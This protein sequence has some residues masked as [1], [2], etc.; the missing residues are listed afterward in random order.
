MKIAAL[1]AVAGAASFA[2]AQ[3]AT[4]GVDAQAT[5]N[6]GEVIAVTISLDGT[7][8]DLGFAGWNI[9]VDVAGGT[10]LSAS[11]DTATA[12]LIDQNAPFGGDPT[13]EVS[14][15]TVNLSEG[16]NAFSPVTAF[17]TG[18]A[19]AT[20]MIDTAG[21]EPSDI[22]ISTRLGD[23]PLGAFTFASQGTPPFSYVG[24]DFSDGSYG[25]ATVSYIP[26]PA[27]M[28]LLGLGGL[29]A[30]RRRR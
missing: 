2:A 29:A 19:L 13:P 5:Y 30:T 9:A 18:G 28:A 11:Y 7:D 24:T 1:L 10:V 6:T 21:A 14:G 4:V 26:A 15:N 16:L 23:S 17:H 27:S 8:I 25:S 22:V 12:P 3:S 20:I